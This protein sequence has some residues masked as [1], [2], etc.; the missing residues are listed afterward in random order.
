MAEIYIISGFL[1]AGKTTLIQ[2]LLKEGFQDKKIAL[3]E[4]DFGDISVDA[5][6]LKSGN[7]EV[8]EINSGCICCN[9]SGNFIKALQ[10]LLRRFK[11]DAIFI[12]P[13]GVGKLSDII[14]SCSDK[15]IRPLA[16]VTAKI[17][18][19]DVKRFKIYLNNF[20]EFFED[21]IQNADTILLSHS[22]D[23]HHKVNEV[24]ELIKELNKN[25]A[26][27]S[28]P[29]D[30]ISV[31]EILPPKY[32]TNTPTLL[33]KHVKK[34]SCNHH[35]CNHVHHNEISSYACNHSHSAEEVFDTVTIRTSKAFTAEDLKSR[36]SYMERNAEGTI[37][38]V[39]GILKGINGYIHLQYLPEN[40]E[41]TN[42]P[43]NGDMLCIIGQG[44]NRQ[45]LINLFDGE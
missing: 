37:L 19:A 30:K 8:T 12:E 40:F 41:I 11:P 39:K 7:V 45:E 22:E 21:Q 13:S 17:T 5:A 33:H 27:L 1:G 9:L 36:I 16:K 10:E 43:V 35:N 14:K 28:R 3:I 15:S 25:A 34:F 4:N 44:L 31:E 29:W 18:V 20:G 24:I 38:R 2:K 32:N 6:L 23:F 42:C 26:I